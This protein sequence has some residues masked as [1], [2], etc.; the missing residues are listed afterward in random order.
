[1]IKNSLR[2]FADGALEAKRVTGEDVKKLRRDILPDGLILREDADTLIALERAIGA[3]CDAAFGV[4]LIETLV[5]FAVWGSRPTGYVDRDTASWL[6]NTLSCG[7]GPTETAGRI[8]FEI[9]KEAQQVDEGLLAFAMRG[10][11]HRKGS[12]PALESPGPLA[13]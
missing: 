7:V 8:A 11:R 3:G 2:A 5:D 6:V 13:A 1:M 12:A 9:V 4:Y 10:A